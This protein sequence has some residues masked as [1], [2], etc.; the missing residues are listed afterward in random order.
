MRLPAYPLAD[1][2]DPVEKLRCLEVV[3]SFFLVGMRIES[4]GRRRRTG[5]KL[6]VAGS[7]VGQDSS[8][9]VVPWAAAVAGSRAEPLQHISLKRLVEEERG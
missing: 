4:R 5:S 1:A 6:A 7:V 8:M 3:E 9:G 2:G